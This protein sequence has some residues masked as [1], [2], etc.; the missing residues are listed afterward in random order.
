VDEF[1]LLA[2]LVALLLVTD[3]PALALWYNT[4]G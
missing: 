3:V 1:A 4:R 2:L